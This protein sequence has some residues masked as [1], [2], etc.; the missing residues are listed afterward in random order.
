M[1]PPVLG[2]RRVDVSS[3]LSNTIRP[4]SQQALQGAQDL[5]AKCAGEQGGTGLVAP[6]LR[7]LLP[8]A[9][10][11]PLSSLVPGTAVRLQTGFPT[12]RIARPVGIQSFSFDLTK[13]QQYWDIDDQVIPLGH[14]MAEALVTGQIS[15]PQMR[16][17]EFVITLVDRWNGFDRHLGWGAGYT[18]VFNLQR[19]SSLSQC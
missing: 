5:A 18:L 19:C 8:I 6:S 16:T 1:F 15:F 4:L 2:A 9:A 12:G 3:S 7:S 17:G 11:E 10:T 13:A 14:D